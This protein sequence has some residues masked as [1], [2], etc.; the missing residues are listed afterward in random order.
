M[1][2]I[3]AMIDEIFDRSYQ[4][5]RSSMNAGMALGLAHLGRSAMDAF[6]ALDAIQFEAPW[7]VRQPRFPRDA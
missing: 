2:R 5:S 1:E 6:R 7:S 4:Q 3:I